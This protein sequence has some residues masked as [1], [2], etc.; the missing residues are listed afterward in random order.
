MSK[1]ILINQTFQ[2]LS[3]GMLMWPSTS[4]NCLA[5][6]WPGSAG[7]LLAKSRH[8]VW[9]GMGWELFSGDFCRGSRRHQPLLCSGR[10]RVSLSLW[11]LGTLASRH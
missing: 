4:F 9:A 1:H 2:S 10:R 11:A 7:V 6:F 5:Y 8:G 3:S